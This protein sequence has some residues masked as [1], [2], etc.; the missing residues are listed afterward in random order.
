M[1]LKTHLKK[2]SHEYTLA[3][4]AMVAVATVA[5]ALLGTFSGLLTTPVLVANAAVFGAVYAVGRFGNDELED[6]ER[7]EGCANA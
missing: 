2:Y 4:N 5:F 3:T 7:E 1:S 6:L